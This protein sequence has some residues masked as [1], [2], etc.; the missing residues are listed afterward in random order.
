MPDTSHVLTVEQ[1]RQILQQ[2]DLSAEQIL[3]VREE[4]YAWLN[5]ALDEYFTSTGALH[6]EGISP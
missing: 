6:S 3:V 1:I 4:L 2:P 5:R